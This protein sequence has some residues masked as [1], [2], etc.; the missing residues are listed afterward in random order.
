MRKITLLLVTILLAFSLNAQHNFGI[1]VGGTSSI[2]DVKNSFFDDSRIIAT[3]NYNIGILYS[4]DINKNIA[5]QT[6]LR[7]VQKGFIQ[8]FGEI[9]IDTTLSMNISLNYLELPLRLNSKIALK[10]INLLFGMGGYFSLGIFGE[11]EGIRNYSDGN[12][13]YQTTSIWSKNKE[14]YNNISPTDPKMF[15]HESGYVGLSRLDYGI[16]SSIGI[17]FNKLRL[18]FDYAY[19]LK[20]IQ[21]ETSQGSMFNHKVYN[22]TLNYI[23]NFSGKGKKS[24]EKS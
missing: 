15:V 10:K 11:I 4:K 19:G 8:R 22:L 1:S 20:N 16:L 7:Y 5:F 17:E 3:Q 2:M 6:D 13:N 14:I 18:V 23:F 21:I 24:V 12:D 9:R